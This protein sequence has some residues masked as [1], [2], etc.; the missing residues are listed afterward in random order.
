LGGQKSNWTRFGYR[1]QNY[2]GVMNLT[3]LFML[4]IILSVTI[5]DVFIIYKKGKYESISAHIIRAAK[6]YPSIPFLIGFVCGHL[7]WSMSDQDWKIVE[8]VLK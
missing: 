5:F 3:V 8:G 2:R 7:F 6:K 1:R 4:V